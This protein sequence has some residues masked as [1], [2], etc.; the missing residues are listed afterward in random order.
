MR[1]GRRSGCSRP[2]SARRTSS[3]FSLVPLATHNQRGRGTLLVGTE[4]PV[5]AVDLVDIVERSMSAPCTSCSSAPTSYSS[6]STRI[7]GRA[8]SRTRFALR[9]RRRSPR[10]PSSTTPT[11]SFPP[12]QSRDD[13]RPRRARRAGGTVG[14]L[15]AELES[16]AA[17]GTQTELAE[18]LR[19]DST[20]DAR[21]RVDRRR[22]DL[23]SP[24]HVIVLND[25]HNTFEGVAAALSR[26]LPGV[27]YEQGT[28]AGR[29]DSQRGPG[30]RLVRPPR[31]GRALLGRLKDSGLT[32][33]PL[34]Q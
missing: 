25:N 24:W 3:A 17:G 4:S 34:E 33:A 5:D 2:A 18:W 16:G 9:S 20:G 13:P 11:S 19:S 29:H 14:E 15:R 31:A 21:A 23:G 32:M 10:T 22:T 1:G 28:P 30:H 7:S 6:S 26:V 27:S 12:G 8:S